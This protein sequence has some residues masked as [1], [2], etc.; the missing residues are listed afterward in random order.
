MRWTDIV[1]IPQKVTMLPQVQSVFGN[2]AFNDG[3]IIECVSLF[4]FYKRTD[5]LIT[6]P[7]NKVGLKV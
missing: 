2:N 7:T 6:S 3:A 4:F 1:P 5:S